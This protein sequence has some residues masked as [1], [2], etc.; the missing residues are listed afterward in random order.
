MIQGEDGQVHISVEQSGCDRITMIRKSGYL[1]AVTSEQ[2][3]LKL[4]GKVQDD[5]PWFGDKDQYETSARVVGAT[6]QVDAKAAGGTTLTM[7]YSLTPD[8]DL[9][10]QST[11]DGRRED[12]V[13]AKRQN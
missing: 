12:P 2:H 11:I 5:G 4:N 7:I 10:E 3:A 1:G 13:V 6:I 8:R 9:M